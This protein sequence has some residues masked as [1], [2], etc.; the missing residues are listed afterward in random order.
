MTSIKRIGPST[1]SPT[2]SRS[3]THNGVVTAVAIS[4]TRAPSLYEQGRNALAAVERQLHEAGTNKSHILMVMIYITDITKKPEFNRAWDEWVD[5]DNLPVR[6]CVEAAL[7]GDDLVELVV[8][9]SVE[10]G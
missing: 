4:E 2:R 5:R 10:R 1:L 8:T 6:A 9:A 3:V 7:E